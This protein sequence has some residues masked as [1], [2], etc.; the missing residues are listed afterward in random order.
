MGYL[1]IDSILKLKVFLSVG[2]I[3]IM[4]MCV[5]F[6]T[7]EQFDFAKHLK[8]VIDELQKVTSNFISNSFSVNIF[9]IYYTILFRFRLVSFF[10]D[11]R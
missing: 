4:R 2:K 8:Q 11:M 6:G 5:F 10:A 9:G 7:E 3:M 1:K